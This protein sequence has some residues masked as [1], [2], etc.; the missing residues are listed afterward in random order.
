M[1]LACS[2][3]LSFRHENFRS[4][5]GAEEACSPFR[6]IQAQSGEH[7]D[8]RPLPDHS[9]I[10][11]A[12]GGAGSEGL[13]QSGTSLQQEAIGVPEAGLVER[14]ACAI[15]AGLHTYYSLGRSGHRGPSPR[16]RPVQE[17]WMTIRIDFAVPALRIA[18][19][20][21][22]LALA[23]CATVTPAVDPASFAAP[24]SPAP[25]A[26]GNT[27]A[28]SGRAAA[29]DQQPEPH[30][31]AQ[32]EARTPAESHLPT[33][34]I[35]SPPQ[36]PQAI[37]LTAEANDLFER[38]R[39]G[40]S[41]PNIS[42][43]LVLY[44]QQWYTNR[45]DYLR[46]M[47]ERSGLYLHH[48]VEELEKRGM[49][50]ELALLPMVESAYNP[51][52][53]SRAKASGLWQFIPA[54]GKRYKLSQNWWKDDRRD[55]VASTN[56]A[57][58]YL[59]LIYEMHG[60]WHLALASY[61]WGENAV[62]RAIAKN[63][64]LG[65]PADYLSLTMPAETRSYVPKLQAL[66][67]IFGNPALVAEL[68]LLNIPNRPF[69]ATITQTANIDVTV[70]AKL[71]GMSTHDLVALNPAH[72]RPV[73]MSETPLVIPADKVDTFLANLKARENSNKPL[74]SWQSYTMRPGDKLEKI[75]QRFGMTLASL[76]TANGF[77]GKIKVRPGSIL[78]VAGKDGASA[79]DLAALAAQAPQADQAPV[80]R[81]TVSIS[82]HGKRVVHAGK[83]T[84]TNRH[85]AAAK[86]GPGKT[87][88]TTVT[89][90]KVRSGDTLASIA[91]HFKVATGDLLRWNRISPNALT[92]GKTLTIEIA[93]NP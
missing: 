36:F 39:N 85:A 2:I 53:F 55:I 29:H 70:A 69:F 17:E 16:C 74:S 23:G 77:K 41:M 35:S 88:K 3:S 93:R 24:A 75:A 81:K 64:A 50:M 59:Q 72:N 82:A 47:V 11:V 44:H 6:V 92:P 90:Y 80:T 37:D 86:A 26:A 5:P 73:I 68:E 48:I 89:R 84:A 27:G 8:N 42:N 91:R 40:F 56:A 65:L 49:P 67:N 54:T 18:C 12:Q 38:M 46:R 51:M 30:A 1:R 66:K 34:V 4:T 60:D 76:N 61:N 19:S 9:A 20:A 28:A 79:A 45:P 43:D 13:A 22:V 32:A 87:A 10:P 71:A 14:R 52:A 58:D 15:I 21:L 31:P 25:E 63:K 57:L 7:Q 33:I 78:L 83:D 62:A